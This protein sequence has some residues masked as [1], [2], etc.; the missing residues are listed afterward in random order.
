MSDRI[1]CVIAEAIYQDAFGLTTPSTCARKADWILAA[2]KAARIAV[3]ELLN[4]P[5][6]S[7]RWK[8]A[9][10]NPDW[11]AHAEA[12]RLTLL[13][14]LADNYWITIQDGLI[15]LSDDGSGTTPAQ[16]RELAAA[17][18]AAAEHAEGQ[19]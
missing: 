12:A 16:T 7:H 10:G 11:D 14:R 13:D 2:L 8:D 19:R 17:L 18:L 6:D 1:K 9:E 4:P 15:H 3:V 5:P